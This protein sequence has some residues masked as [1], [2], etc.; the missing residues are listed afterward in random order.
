MSLGRTND[1]QFVWP[2]EHKDKN[3]IILKWLY[4]ET[5][6]QISETKLYEFITDNNVG[7]EI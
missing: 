4:N 3:F 7:F 6:K 2:F 1:R 5:V